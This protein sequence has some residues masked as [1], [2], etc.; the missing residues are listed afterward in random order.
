MVKKPG[1]AEFFLIFHLLML[2]DMAIG[3]I[4]GN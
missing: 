1:Q 4:F 2:N 3:L